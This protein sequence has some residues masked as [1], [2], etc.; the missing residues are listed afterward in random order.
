MLDV[1]VDKRATQFNQP[2]M[3]AMPLMPLNFAAKAPVFPEPTKPLT[4]RLTIVLA[5][6]QQAATAPL[7]FADDWCAQLTSLMLECAALNPGPLST[8]SNLAK[9]LLSNWLA[10][11]EGTGRAHGSVRAP[12]SGEPSLSKDPCLLQ[13]VA[14][15]IVDVSARLGPVD[16]ERQRTPFMIHWCAHMCDIEAAR[17]TAGHQDFIT[18]CALQKLHALWEQLTPTFSLPARPKSPAAAPAAAPEPQRPPRLL[19]IP[20]DLFA[21]MAAGD[22]CLGFW[23]ASAAASA[24]AYTPSYVAPS[25]SSCMTDGSTPASGRASGYDG[26]DD[27]V[28]VLNSS[29]AVDFVYVG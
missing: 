29:G 24:A 9:Q 18:E 17:S 14:Y 15:T 5:L 28:E 11:L 21:A 7:L 26:C 3:D 19:P 20:D 23:Q 4:R 6:L 2:A 16:A 1:F 25:L 13:R 12:A 27:Y 8:V 10:L 22:S